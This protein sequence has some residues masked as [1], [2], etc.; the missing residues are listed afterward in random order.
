MDFHKNKPIYLQII[1]MIKNDIINGVLKPGEKMPSVRTLSKM[2]KVNPTTVQRVFRELE[3]AGYTYTERGLGAFVVKKE[4][5]EYDIKHEKA[6]QL[7]AEYIKEMH[8]IGYDTTAIERLIK[9]WE[10]EH[11]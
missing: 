5:L 8:Q 3:L 4:G 6:V 2:Y 7:T 11:D 10:D 9:E 1:E